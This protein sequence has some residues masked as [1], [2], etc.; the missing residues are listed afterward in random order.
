M[1][2]AG[3]SARRVLVLT[4]LVCAW[5]TCG[6]AQQ[7][8]DGNTFDLRGKVINATTGAGVGNALVQVIGASVETQFSGADGTF[9]FPGMP[10]GTYQL[11]VTKP[12]FFNQNQMNRPGMDGM[13]TVPSDDDAVLKMTPEGI[14][15]GALESES[16]QPLEGVEVRAQEWRV[17]N[18]ARSLQT[19]GQAVT[20]DEGQ[21]R[22][23][24]LQP[25][26]Y[27]VNFLPKARGGTRIYSEIAR[28]TREEEG[29]APQFYPGVTDV[30][31]ATAVR[32]K[33]GAQVQLAQA[34]RKQ[35]LFDVSG[36]VRGANA[37][38]GFQVMLMEPSGEALQRDIHMDPKSGEFQIQGVPEG[39]YELVATAADMGG[40]PEEE[41]P[42]LTATAP[43][44][45]NRDV[46]GLVLMLGRGA[47]VGVM[48]EDEVPVE[49]QQTHQ[50]QLTITS[51]GFLHSSQGLVVPPA[52]K[53]A[54]T[55]FEGLMPGTYE[56]Q[57]WA[58]N[59]PK[60][61]VASLRCGDVDLLRDDLTITAGV[62]MPPIEVKLRNDGAELNVE[63]KNSDKTTPITVV[64]YSVDYP[65][66]SL[67]L[68][69]L[70]ESTANLGNLRP[71][72]YKVVALQGAQEVE[73][74][75]AVFVEKYV[76]PAREV[77]LRE[78]DKVSVEVE[79]AV[80]ENRE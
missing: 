57:A 7:G 75:D 44:Q 23:A 79:A 60:G 52:D 8:A 26:T 3:H 73:F 4:A 47:A 51:E 41:R 43:I 65:K 12:G 67:A 31:S 15:Y 78:G 49:G 66:R 74:R 28:K 17:V 25:G 18:G 21:F 29:M 46:T 71:G 45:L 59:V 68:G 72:T 50:V 35:R 24:E 5:A 13:K 32:I 1:R 61:Y 53:G 14:I 34:L 11:S 9:V 10:R 80:E 39:R 19:A 62:A 27:Y 55:R 77:S 38:R 30:G 6:W 48:L 20:N 37:T 58:A 22:I 2:N 56:V 16:G 40:G 76:A 64:L 70:P 33:A 69:V 36:M 42:P 63:V 54:P